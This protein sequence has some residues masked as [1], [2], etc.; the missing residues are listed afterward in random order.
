MFQLCNVSF[1]FFFCF[2]PHILS[3][4]SGVVFTGGNMYTRKYMHAGLLSCRRHSHYTTTPFCDIDCSSGA[5]SIC[6]RI[7]M[8]E[9]SAGNPSSDR[10]VCEDDA[11]SIVG[12]DSHVWSP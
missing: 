4:L 8:V 6:H 2:F 1:L 10:V 3:L 12:V 5:R 9:K 11:E 7:A